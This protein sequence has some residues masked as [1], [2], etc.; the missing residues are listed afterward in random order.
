M[1]TFFSQKLQQNQV[2][3]KAIFVWAA[4]SALFYFFVG[5][6]VER[7]RFVLLFGSYSLLFLGYVYIVKLFIEDALSSNN[8]VIFILIG[9]GISFRA[10]LLFYEPNLSDDYYR[11]YWDGL[12]NIQNISP[13]AYKPIDIIFSDLATRF[14]LS[15][16]LYENLNSKNYYSVYPAFLQWMFSWAA[17]I[18]GFN[19]L[20]LFVV[21][22]KV[23][24]LFFEIG[25]ITL[26]LAI[27]KHLNLPTQNILWYALNPLVIIELTGNLHFEAFMIFFVLLSFYL[28]YR[29]KHWWASA[30]AVGFA[31][32]SKLIPLIFLP[33]LIKRIGFKQ[34][35]YYGFVL[36]FISLVLFF[37]FIDPIIIPNIFE[38]VGLYYNK[39]E[40][41]GSIYYLLRWLGYQYVGWNMI[42]IIGKLTAVATFLTILFFAFFEKKVNLQALIQSS[43]LALT[44]Y[45]LLANIVHPWYVTPLI[46]FAV[47]AQP[48]YAIIWGWLVM[49]SYYAYSND[50]YTE[51]MLLIIVEYL[52][53]FAAI[54]WEWKHGVLRLD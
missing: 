29:F 38:S 26:L 49:L 31:F 43:M 5:Y 44:V 50:A 47:I 24:I 45:L 21:L 17:G 48:K 10:L 52:A 19:N 46:A 3:L 42:A 6:V 40:F 25:T 12:L 39:F 8:N 1:P 37:K 36:M 27:L 20:A 28:I 54:A 33:F 34:S 53:V 32:C 18:A 22:L 23:S 51:S 30:I 15:Y 2:N 16:E 13:Y 35:I 9:A 14:G 4:V 7:H 11:F 41:N